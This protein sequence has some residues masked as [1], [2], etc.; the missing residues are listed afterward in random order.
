MASRAFSVDVTQLLHG[1]IVVIMV[2]PAKD[3]R[4]REAEI[5]VRQAV[6]EGV[7]DGCDRVG[8]S[9]TGATGR[10]QFPRRGFLPSEEV[11][12]DLDAFGGAFAWLGGAVREDLRQSPVGRV[13]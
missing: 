1:R 8:F 10:A 7:A 12:S 9:M 5:A 3:Q 4:Y 6:E 2:P 13:E 11:L